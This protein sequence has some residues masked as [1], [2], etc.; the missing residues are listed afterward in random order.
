MKA[1]ICGCGACGSYLDPNN[2]HIITT[3]H[4]LWVKHGGGDAK[5]GSV[6]PSKL[7]LMLAD[8]GF[9]V[10]SARQLAERMQQM[11]SAKNGCVQFFELCDWYRRHFLHPV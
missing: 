1:E 7:K 2:V 5:D 9:P 4:E 3:I 8:L 6:A 11:D 10:N